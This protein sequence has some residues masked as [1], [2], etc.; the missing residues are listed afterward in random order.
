MD[1]RGSATPSLPAEPRCSMTEN[2][3]HGEEEL[4]EETVNFISTLYESLGPLLTEVTKLQNNQDPPAHLM[5]DMRAKLR[6]MGSTVSDARKKMM[7]YNM[8][9][10]RR[11]AKAVHEKKALREQQLRQQECNEQLG[12]IPIAAQRG[13]RVDLEPVKSS[14][15]QDK[16]LQEM[17]PPEL[18][19]NKAQERAHR[20]GVS[21]QD[22]Q[23]V[24][25]VE[26]A[27]GRL[28]PLQDIADGSSRVCMTP[29]GVL[30]KSACRLDGMP[31]RP[32][33]DRGQM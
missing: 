10:K 11:L 24:P 23:F 29:Q 31:S 2:T 27:S 22:P 12:A 13:Y 9:L 19:R 8:Y 30:Q 25:V 4:D 20:R 14:M 6:E 16:N 26:E 5:V 28:R 33:L 15:T 18:L 1:Q 7:R 32:S 3:L 17:P 21:L